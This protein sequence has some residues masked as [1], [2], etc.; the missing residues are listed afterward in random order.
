[1][2]CTERTVDSKTILDAP[3]GTP[4]DVGHV[5][6]HFVPFG[7][8]VSVSARLVVCAKR[9]LGSEIVLDNPVVLLVDET[10]VEARFGLFGDSAHLDTR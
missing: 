2:V 1:M 10:Q 4:S 8:G 7:D 3:D 5:E 9:T 6:S